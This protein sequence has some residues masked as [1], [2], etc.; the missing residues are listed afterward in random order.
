MIIK[1]AKLK[2]TFMN[3]KFEEVIDVAH[4]RWWQTFEVVFGFPFLAAIVLQLVV[5]LSLPRGLLIPAVILG[6]FLIIVGAAL[7]IR[8]RRQFMQ[9]SQPTNPGPDL[10]NLTY[11]FMEQAFCWFS[12]YSRSSIILKFKFT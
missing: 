6:V 8:A 4:K 11:E 12:Q 1:K 2:K 3:S 10:N 5:P 7:G 9:H